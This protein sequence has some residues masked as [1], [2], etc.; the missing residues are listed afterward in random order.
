MIGRTEVISRAMTVPKA[1]MASGDEV[2]ERPV[3]GWVEVLVYALERGK[4]EIRYRWPDD[5]QGEDTE[6]VAKRQ[7]FAKLV[8]AEL[9]GV[10]AEGEL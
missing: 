6:G 3:L 9:E 10:L 8:I 1:H 5:A 2:P 4:C 7:R